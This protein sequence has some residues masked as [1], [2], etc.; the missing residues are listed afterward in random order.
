MFLPVMTESPAKSPAFRLHLPVGFLGISA[1]FFFWFLELFLHL[2]ALLSAR[3]KYRKALQAASRTE[4]WVAC[5]SD[6]LD[7]VNGI[8]LASRVQLRELRRHGHQA[9]LFGVA[10]RD[11]PP[12]REDP[13]QALILAPGRYSVDQVGYPQSE[14]VVLDLSAF[15]AFVLENPVDMIEFE[16]FASPVMVLTLVASKIMGIRTL[17]HYR[18]DIV[19]YIEMYVKYKL[20]VVFLKLWIKGVTR[21][22]GPVIVPSEAS[23]KKVEAMGFAPGDIYKL[24]RGVDLSAFHPRLRDRNFWNERRVPN[25]GFLLLY[26][27]RLSP[28]KNLG[29][30]ADAFREALKTR[31]DLRLIVV[32]DGP[33]RADFESRIQSTGRA[34]FTGFLE[35]EN[36]A[37]AFASA[38]LFVF[39]SL[40]ETFG[41]SPVEAMAS[42]LPCLVSDLGGPCESIV[43]NV[44]GEIFNHQE[45]NSLRDGML[46]LAGDPEKLERYRA[47]ARIRAEEFTYENSA[48]AFWN[49]YTS[50]WKT[51]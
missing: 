9:F 4:P 5:V 39:P 18:T 2:P 42:G 37:K 13:D 34:H 22:A 47:A 51:K 7:E 35:G 45:P 48:R 28:E 19:T 25:D 14:M 12:R 11:R 21:S 33:S 17:W 3:R 29:T 41:N 46:S 6:N 30:L 8:A 1:L 49:L 32:G 50:L 24:P 38:D 36:L 43:P 44:C 20:G 26:V 16:T 40:T 31:P 10:F 23:R 27:G 15:I